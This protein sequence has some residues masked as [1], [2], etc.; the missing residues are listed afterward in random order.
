MKKIVFLL[1]LLAFFVF[2]H[3]DEL[4]Y[5]K[6]TISEKIKYGTAIEGVYKG[7]Y[8]VFGTDPK[9]EEVESD[10][11][12][13]AN[14]I[15][16][17]WGKHELSFLGFPFR[18]ISKHLG[19]SSNIGKTLSNQQSISVISSYDF[20]NKVFFLYD[21]VE[22]WINPYIVTLSTQYQGRETHFLFCFSNA[23]RFYVLP[24]S[25]LRHSFA[26]KNV[27]FITIELTS[28]KE[29]NGNVLYEKSGNEKWPF[30]VEFVQEEFQ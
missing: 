2:C 17:G 7:H 9:T 19:E 22:F 10:S 18:L 8:K 4:S 24:K 30:C 21:S 6:I 15:V 14:M 29:E 3:K 5:P 13:N 25:E 12:G 1:F 11:V 26:L 23:N 27:S 28:I 20:V 16:T